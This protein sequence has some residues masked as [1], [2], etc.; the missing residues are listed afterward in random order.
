M[1]SC[2]AKQ[3]ICLILF[4]LATTLVTGRYYYPYFTDEE[5]E[6]E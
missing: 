5:M 6:T 2:C 4:N 1:A 3:S